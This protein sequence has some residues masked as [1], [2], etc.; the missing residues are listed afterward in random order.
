MTLSDNLKTIWNTISF[1]TKFVLFISIICY[2]LDYFNK[3]YYFT[4]LVNIPK[5]T[6]F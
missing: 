6:I 3:E 2:L 1:G 4:L 5:K